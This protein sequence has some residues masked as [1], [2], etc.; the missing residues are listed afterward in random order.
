MEE[1]LKLYLRTMINN[2]GSD[3]HVKSG[4]IVRVRIDGILTLLGKEILSGE[5]VEDIAKCISTIEQYKKLE[6][7]KNLDLTYILGD[8]HRFRVNFFYQMDGLSAVFRLIPV[9]IATLEEL[10]LPEVIESFTHIQR[11]LILVTGVTGSGKSTTLAAIIDKINRKE[12]KHI[13][14]IEDPIEFIHKDRGCL[15]TRYRTRYPFVFR[16]IKSSPK[17]RPRH[18]TCGGNEGFREYR[19]CLTCCK[20]GSLSIVYFTHNRC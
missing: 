12:Q 1:Q 20:Y 5:N 19:H 3:L 6:E 14:T 10:N 8:E 16:C 11:G 17:R 9:E 13:I 18:H 2:G 7:D 15:I 4:A